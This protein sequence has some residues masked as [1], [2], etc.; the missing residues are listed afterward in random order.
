M[1]CLYV[2]LLYM[3]GSFT[4]I[5]LFTATSYHI[6]PTIIA[7]QSFVDLICL[8]TVPVTFLKLLLQIMQVPEVQDVVSLILTQL[9]N[10]SLLIEK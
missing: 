10:N 3:R 9:W 1:K 6:N 7:I 5:L 8:V 2:L 4:R